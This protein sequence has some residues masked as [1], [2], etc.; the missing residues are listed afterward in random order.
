MLILDV[1]EPLGKNSSILKLQHEEI[2]IWELRMIDFEVDP[3]SRGSKGDRN[4]ES[5]PWAV[6]KLPDG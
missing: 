1:V 4:G 5:G 2:A 3:R 6:R